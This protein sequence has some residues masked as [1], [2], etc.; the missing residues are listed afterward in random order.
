MIYE[1]L[2]LNEGEFDWNDDF[3]SFVLST[4]LKLI[5]FMEKYLFKIWNSRE[6]FQNFALS[7]IPEF[8]R[9]QYHEL[10]FLNIH[11]PASFQ[12]LHQ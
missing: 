3:N 9:S 10:H 11:Q 1:E 8:S 12:L 2:E 5:N 7:L 4:N 6:N